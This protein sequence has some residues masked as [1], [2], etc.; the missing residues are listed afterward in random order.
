MISQPQSQQWQ[1]YLLHLC[2]VLSLLNYFNQACSLLESPTDTVSTAC[3][4]W[5]S[6]AK[7]LQAY[8]LHHS[9]LH[10]SAQ[11]VQRNALDL[12]QIK[13]CHCAFESPLPWFPDTSLLHTWGFDS[14]KHLAK[15]LLTLVYSWLGL[16]R[17]GSDKWSAFFT[18]V[19]LSSRLLILPVIITTAENVAIFVSLDCLCRYIRYIFWAVRGWL[20]IILPTAAGTAVWNASQVLERHLRIFARFTEASGYS[21]KHR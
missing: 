2:I 18:G 20:P 10:R 8:F 17:P 16:Q 4:C 13:I 21:C 15:M 11:C 1:S 12:L 9:A 14:S 6:C 5:I 7:L 19:K 3:K